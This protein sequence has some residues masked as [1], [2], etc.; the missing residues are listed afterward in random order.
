MSDETRSW[1]EDVMPFLDEL[2]A[3][4]MRHSTV[5]AESTGCNRISKVRKRGSKPPFTARYRTLVL[6]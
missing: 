1:M 4:Y 6:Y 5:D 2:R 3:I